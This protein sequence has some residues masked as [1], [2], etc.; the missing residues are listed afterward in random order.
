MSLLD[1]WMEREEGDREMGLFSFFFPQG[2]GE[3]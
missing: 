3:S 2:L 1:G